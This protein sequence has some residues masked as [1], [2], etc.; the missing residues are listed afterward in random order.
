IAKLLDRVKDLHSCPAV[1]QKV[2]QLTAED[3]YDV[4]DV[5]LCLANDPAL[6][7][8]ILRFVNSSHF[9][10]RSKIASLDRATMILGRRSLRLAVLN[11]GLT[12]R[13][14]AATPAKLFD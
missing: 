5:G 3:D 12:E 9:G 4:G 14:L 8:A 6:A 2:L 11:F 10:L 1:V 7:G 13:L